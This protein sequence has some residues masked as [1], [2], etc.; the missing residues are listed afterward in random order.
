MNAPMLSTMSIDYMLYMD[1]YVGYSL[2]KS[3]YKAAC[4]KIYNWKVF[5]QLI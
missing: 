1:I 5:N 3:L 4:N 2:W